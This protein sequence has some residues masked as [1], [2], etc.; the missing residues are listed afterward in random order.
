MPKH[1]SIVLDSM[2]FIYLFEEDERFI[3]KVK[4]LFTA[5]EKGNLKGVTSI[6]SPLEVLSAQKLE[7]EPEKRA[8]FAKFF[9]KTPNLSVHPL[10]WKV[11]EKAAGLRRKNPTLKAP[12][13]VQLATAIE[14]KSRH[15]ITNDKKLKKIRIKSLKTILVN[16]V[17]VQKLS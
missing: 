10:S 12:D 13:A 11:M 17:D 3:N 2:I 9:Q 15:Y 6:V 8:A 5:I 7:K 1:T 14:T 4:P 16:E